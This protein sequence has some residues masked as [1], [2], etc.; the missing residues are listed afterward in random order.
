MIDFVNS[1]IGQLIIGAGLA[2]MGKYTW[3]RWL[4]KTSRVTREECFEHQ[5][6]CAGARNTNLSKLI[7]LHDDKLADGDKEFNCIGTQL[8]KIRTILEA[9]LDISLKLCKV[10]PAIDCE[11]LMRV[12]AKKGL[13]LN[14]PKR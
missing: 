2:L 5:K 3:D 9:V 6:L 10:N 4:S 1:P 14:L 13:E 12:L 11:D 7:G 8:E